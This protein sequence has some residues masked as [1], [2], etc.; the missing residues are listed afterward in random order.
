MFVENANFRRKFNL[1]FKYRYRI[2]KAI[3]NQSDFIVHILCFQSG[4]LFII[5]IPVQTFILLQKSVISRKCC[6]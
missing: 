2:Q 1:L 5:S 3:Q 6:V 4:F